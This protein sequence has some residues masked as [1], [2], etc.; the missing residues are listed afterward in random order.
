VFWYGGA[1]LREKTT[2]ARARKRAKDKP[3]IRQRKSGGPGF[4]EVHLSNET[5]KGTKQRQ[6]EKERERKKK[7]GKKHT[8][9]LLKGK[10]VDKRGK[11][12]PF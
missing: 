4:L 9:T 8:A 10:G 2:Q 12:K 1:R 3:Q 6:K 5:C 7:R 11:K